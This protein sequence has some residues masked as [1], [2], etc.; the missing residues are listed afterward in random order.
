[1]RPSKLANA[2]LSTLS[3][4]APGVFCMANELT[5]SWGAFCWEGSGKPSNCQPE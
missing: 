1:M 2:V 3:G 5:M 4:S